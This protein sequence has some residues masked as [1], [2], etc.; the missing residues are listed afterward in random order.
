M[1]V[2]Y[3]PQKLQELFNGFKSNLEKGIQTSLAFFNGEVRLICPPVDTP[4][5]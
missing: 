4:H 1:K 2:D 5:E 3:N